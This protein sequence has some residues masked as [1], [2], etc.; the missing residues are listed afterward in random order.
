VVRLAELYQLPP[1]DFRVSDEHTVTVLYA[2]RPFSQMDRSERIRACYQ[3]A[4]LQWIARK[5]LTNSSL[6]ER[7]GISAANAAMA[8]R[9]IGETLEAGLIKPDDPENRSRKHAR[10]VPYWA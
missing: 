7:F 6:R 2:P 1:P 4:G 3:H 8:S 5:H 9:I 10:Y